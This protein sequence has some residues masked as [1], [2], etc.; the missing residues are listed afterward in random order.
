MQIEWESRLISDS[1]WLI[2]P[3]LF[4]ACSQL[5]KFWASRIKGCHWRDK[6]SPD[7]EYIFDWN[8][9]NYIE[10]KCKQ[11]NIISSVILIAQIEVLRFVYPL[12]LS[13]GKIHWK[14]PMSHQSS[15]RILYQLS[16]ILKR[17]FEKISIV[18]F[19]QTLEFSFLS[20]L[21]LFSTFTSFQI[22]LNNIDK[23]DRKYGRKE[24]VDIVYWR[25]QS[26]VQ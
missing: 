22:P 26:L 16:E 13:N 8:C 7:V 4:H 23:I 15:V 11:I 6:T 20:N 1:H 21:L 5:A 18:T 24:C 25:G 19:F 10:L 9:N 17:S 12:Y 14:N 2:Y 3:W